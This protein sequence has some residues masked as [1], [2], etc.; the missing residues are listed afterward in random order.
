MTEKNLIQ[1]G[2][3]SPAA[4]ACIPMEFE[5]TAPLISWDNGWI[6]EFWYYFTDVVNQAIY[7]PQYYLALDLPGGNPIK[8]ERLTDDFCC[9][10][11]AS[12][13][14]DNGYYGRQNE[15]LK[16]CVALIKKGM[17][18]Q[19]DVLKLQE[20]W[21]ESLPQILKNVLEGKSNFPYCQSDS[22]E[23]TEYKPQSLIDVLKIEMYKA[24][25]NN[26]ANEIQRIQNEMKKLTD[27]NK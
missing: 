20:L 5:P 9:L 8:M 12:E 24:V 21:I 4:R 25:Q 22:P 3:S 27:K 17:P 15:Y 19:E 10:G 2:K 11:A 13:L 18:S 7:M 14:V 6:A 1:L 26:D 16:N 23:K